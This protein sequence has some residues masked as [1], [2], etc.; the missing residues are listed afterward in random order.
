MKKYCG[1]I[2][3]NIDGTCPYCDLPKPPKKRTHN[4]KWKDST[5]TA[6]SDKRKKELQA[7]AQRDGFENAS[8]AITAWKNGEA[9]LVKK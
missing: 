3:E 1:H 5:R 7:A 2:S 9:I 8:A 4:P 6:R